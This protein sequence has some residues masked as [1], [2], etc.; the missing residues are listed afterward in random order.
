VAKTTS[1][2]GTNPVGDNE[3]PTGSTAPVDTATADD[4]PAIVTPPPPGPGEAAVSGEVVKDPK[5]LKGKVIKYFG[6]AD[7]RHMRTADWAAN[8]VPDQE[9]V[10]WTKANGFMVPVSRF[11]EKA[12]ELL[13][14]LAPEF[15]EVDLDAENEAA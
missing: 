1:T 4:S 13:A 3:T 11:N 7:D 8:G 9:G 15:R 14:S 12:L 6:V 10:T 5:P 2:S